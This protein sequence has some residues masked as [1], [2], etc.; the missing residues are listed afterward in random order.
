VKCDFNKL[1]CC[2][3]GC[4]N[5]FKCCGECPCCSSCKDMEKCVCC[6][7]PQKMKSFMPYGT[8]GAKP[9]NPLDGGGAYDYGGRGIKGMDAG[10]TQC[11]VRC[12]AC[13]QAPKSLG[14]SGFQHGNR[15]RYIRKRKNLS[16]FFS[17]EQLLPLLF[18]FRE[19]KQ[20]KRPLFWS[21]W[22]RLRSSEP[23]A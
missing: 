6:D 11:C 20:T 9:T 13:C 22:R 15:G 1:K 19:E 12:S 23:S 2:N 18:P 4:D 14:R 17:W 3:D 8:P 16:L 7:R 21:P 10:L 5:V